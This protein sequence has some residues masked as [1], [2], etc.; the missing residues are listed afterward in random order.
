MTIQQ[1]KYI[2]ALHKERHFARAAEVCM[3]TQPRH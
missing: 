3:V 2:V 1:L